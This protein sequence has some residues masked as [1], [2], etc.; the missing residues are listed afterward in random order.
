MVEATEAGLIVPVANERQFAAPGA[1]V[2]C[3]DHQVALAERRA[4]LAIHLVAADAQREGG[5]GAEIGEEHEALHRGHRVTALVELRGVDRFVSDQDRRAGDVLPE[6]FA[7]R[8]PGLLAIELV[9]ARLEVA[10][11]AVLDVDDREGVDRQ[12]ATGAREE[13]AGQAIAS[14]LLDGEDVRL[15][16]AG[17]AGEV[18]AGQVTLATFGA[19]QLPEFL[20]EVGNLELPLPSEGEGVG[21]GGGVVGIEEDGGGYVEGARDAREDL[22]VDPALPL[23]ETGH[24]RLGETDLVREVL[25]GEATFFA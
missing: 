13:V 7:D 23:L 6:L 5:A 9:H 8:A 14:P 20:V 24:L 1:T 19:N 22:R 17:L 11:D 15:G 21:R 18:V 10:N 12:D 3:E 4:P 16:V 25:A 2:G